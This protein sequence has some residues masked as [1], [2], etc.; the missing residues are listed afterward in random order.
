VGAIARAR[1]LAGPAQPCSGAFVVHPLDYT[2]TAGGSAVHLY[3]SNGAGTALGDLDG[4]GDLDIVMANL[5]GPNAVL[6]ND[7]GLRFRRQ[8]LPHGASRAAHVVDVD[9]DGL[10]DIVFTRQNDKP[11]LLR[12]TGRAGGE[13]FQAGELPDVHNPFYTL[14]WGDLDR[15]GDL[16]L[17]AASYDTELLKLQGLIFQQR[18]GVGVF[19]YERDGERFVQHRLA[20]QADGLAIALPDLDGDGRRD[21][22]VG[23]DFTRPDYVWLQAGGAHDWRAIM[24]ADQ[25]TENTMSLDLGDVDNDGAQEI[26]AADMKPYRKDAATLARWL[27]MMRKMTLPP[28]SD[29]P[30]QPENALLVRGWDGRWRNEA[31]ERMLDSSGWSWSARFGDTV[32]W[33]DGAVSSVDSVAPQHLLVVMRG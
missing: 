25:I 24:P 13:R 17:V 8:D 15:D 18:G 22:W 9:G 16:D 3:E 19:V 30:Q 2:T 11:S 31:Y 14:A 7:G 12:N 1:P 29:D 27:P 28:N 23:N 32:T 10:L 33:P 5:A 21:I 4:D 26:L 6:W 20:E